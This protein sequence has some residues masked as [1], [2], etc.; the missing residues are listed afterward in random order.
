MMAKLIDHNS[1][2][3]TK[4][5]LDLFSLP[6]TQI[7][8]ESGYWHP[9]R[10]VNTCTTNGPWQ[11]HVQANPQYLQ[12]A[13][14]YLY[15]KLRIVRADGTNLVAD[16]AGG[17]GQQP[18]VGD[19]VGPINLI[20]KTLFKQ[21]KVHIN[22]RQ[23][24]DSGDNYA[25]R[26]FLETELNYGEAAK[27]TQLTAGLYAKDKP[28][29][30][31][32]TAENTGW[33][34]RRNWFNESRVVEVMAP[35]HCELFQ[36]D[37]LLLDNTELYMELHRNS[38]AFALMSF[39]DGINYKLEV[40]DMIW[41]VR[42]VEILKSVQMGLETALVRNP[43]KYP[44]RRIQVTK[45]H[46][47]P[48]RRAAPANTLFTGQIPRRLVV[49]FVNM[50]SYYGN[51]QT[52]PFR[53]NNHTVTKIKVMAGG[54]V[55]PREPIEM[56]F[57]NNRFMRGYV[58]LFEGLGQGREDTGNH[59]TLNDFKHSHCLFVFDLTPDEQ[60]AGHWELIKEGSVSVDVE[61]GVDVPEPGIEMIVY[62]EFDNLV[63]I[64]HN[65]NVYFD[66]NV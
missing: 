6:P 26:A 13:K 53:F 15:M 37:K 30:R 58:N 66:Y 12:L 3:S 64:D 2:P 65:R 41:Y 17:E 11:F 16:Q 29:D 18:I 34:W 14:N 27:T 59:I 46:I 40:Q 24:F 25:Y 21:V 52:S 57:T 19:R 35:I 56:D 36:S 39:A 22:G 43:A 54:Q 1:L 38:D 50:R 23:A 48:G 60:D 7:S 10:L 31:V 55:F 45:L 44:V 4:T 61:F 42:K 32:D 63:M 47:A 51:Y 62:A 5:E 9:V 49:G 28:A 8:I 20:G 33:G